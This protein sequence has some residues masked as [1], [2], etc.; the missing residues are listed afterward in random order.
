MF[1][2]SF[3]KR[4]FKDTETRSKLAIT[5]SILFLLFIGYRI[6]LPGIN[7]D[8]L[9]YLFSN[10]TNSGIGGFFNSMTG[11]SFSRMSIFALSVTPY[12]SASI[13]TQ[14]LAAFIPKLKEVANSGS[15]GKQKMEKLTYLFGCIIAIA[16]SVALAVGFGQQGLFTNYS[17]WTVAY[18]TV[19]WTLGACFLIWVG[20]TITNKLIGNGISLILM[21]N[22]LSTLPSNMLLIYNT[23]SA[24]MG[25]GGKLIVAMCMIVIVVLIF[26]YVV[27]LNNA[28][29]KIRL[30]SSY[31]AG[32]RFTNANENIMPLKLNMGGVMPIILS[33]SMMS[34]PSMVAQIFKPTAGTF[35]EFVVNCTN[36]S[37]WFRPDNWIYSLGVLVFIPATFIFSSFYSKMS[38]N[39]KDIADNLRKSG[40]V[41]DGI[42]PGHPT[43]EYLKQQL[44]SM[45]IIGTTMLLLIAL[46]PT[47]VSGLLGLSGLS[48]GG[49]SIIIIVGTILETKNTIEARTSSTG[50]KSLVRRTR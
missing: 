18:A 25:I 39:P 32:M 29:R 26:A 30:T 45:L 27:V 7:P 44:S 38:F 36:Q 17:F 2:L 4:I 37:N 13:V 8:Y 48:F 12:I 33:S 21:F 35:W 49:T 22:I 47:I 24:S 10:L 19:V 46:A 40:S 31:K 11:N 5:I 3:F 28:D 50:Y 43:A 41:I 6:P 23:S 14:M 15:V 34:I 20:Q 42:R 16:E 9:T 1:V